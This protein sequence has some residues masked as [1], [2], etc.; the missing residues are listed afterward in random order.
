[1]FFTWLNLFDNGVLLVLSNQFL[2]LRR[3]LGSQLFKNHILEIFI[4]VDSTDLQITL[5][6][7]SSKVGI[8]LDPARWGP[9]TQIYYTTSAWTGSG[10]D[11]Q[12]ATQIQ[13]FTNNTV[14]LLVLSLTRKQVYHP[15]LKP[16]FLCSWSPHWF[17]DLFWSCSY[18][19]ME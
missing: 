12:I 19:V 11:L 3:L 2:S 1:M 18:G 6:V 4:Q 8:S 14:F 15:F 13:F 5:S 17:L 7:P 10:P 16:T 9:I